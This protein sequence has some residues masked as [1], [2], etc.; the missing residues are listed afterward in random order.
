MFDAITYGKG[1][2]V[3]WMIEQFIGTEQFRKGIGELPAQ[4]RVRQHRRPPTFGKGWT[5]HRTGRSA[6]S[7]T[8]GS[9]SEGF[10]QIEVQAVGSGVKLSQRRFLA[11]PDESDTTIWKVPVQLRGSAGGADLRAQGPALR[12]RG[13]RRARG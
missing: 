8:P 10:P 13:D 5:G 9:T 3:L 4:A 1:S 6:R 2:A 11:I 12:R 7:W